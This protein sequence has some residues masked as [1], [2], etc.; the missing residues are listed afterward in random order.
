MKKYYKIEKKKIKIF[1]IIKKSLYICNEKEITAILLH[2]ER[3]GFH[4]TSYMKF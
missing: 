1:V 4:K 2:P 3:W